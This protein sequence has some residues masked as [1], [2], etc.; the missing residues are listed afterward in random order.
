M[1]FEKPRGRN[2]LWPALALLLLALIAVGDWLTVRT[3]RLY[4]DEDS[5]VAR[6]EGTVWQHFGIRG[7]QVMPEI[8]TD[9]GAR[10]VFPV[11]TSTPHRLVFSAHPDADAEYQ[12]VWHG[13]GKSKQLT[14]RKI[15]G[16]FAENI[17]VPTSQGDLEFIVHG[18]I[19]WFDLRLTRAFFLWPVYLGGSLLLALALKKSQPSPP[20]RA[21]IGNGLTCIVTTFLFLAL[22]EGT[23]RRFALKLPAKVLAARHGFGFVPP[24]P[25]WIES[26]RYQ[27]RLRPNL[28][29]T[30]AWEHGDTIRMGFIPPEISGS[31]KH[32]YPFR[33]DAEGFRNPSIRAQIDVAA[34]GDSFTDAM[35]L[36]VE[37]SWPARLEQITG[38]KVQ[39]YGVSSFGPQ[40]EFYVLEDFALA[41]RPREVVIAFFAGNDLFDAERFE[42]WQRSGDKPGEETTGWRLQ[43]TYRRHQTSYFET[44][45]R[46]ALPQAW[47]SRLAAASPPVA[48][49]KDSLFD[50]GMFN[51]PVA[52][53]FRFALMPAYVQKLASSRAELERSRGWELT[54]TTFL[55]MRETCARAS[56]RFTIMFIPSK[57]EAYWPLIERSLGPEKLQRAIDFSCLYNHM[58]LRA[59]TIHANRLAQNDLVR[60]FAAQQN[61]SFLDLTPALEQNAAAGRA[62]YFPDDAHWNAAGHALA[63]EE[64]A[65]FLSLT[66]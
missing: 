48:A 31:E 36:A 9:D 37:E 17:S 23:L 51:L 20:L 44:M 38:K 5:T 55:R 19:A 8:I 13:D 47:Q 57:A 32:R 61:I 43:K 50:R 65:K 30:C 39:N 33:T 60:E 18:H 3:Q 56:A 25:R 29:T 59:A 35:T 45:A 24:D 63:A 41:H 52:G 28:R 10:F 12:I 21:A 34:L 66:P 2:A 14:A 40:Q 49:R 15:S 6:Q 42:Q 4:V 46:L 11:T 53:N 22:I 7:H 54:R 62:V 58:P 26:S 1:S 27:T 64:L 16:A